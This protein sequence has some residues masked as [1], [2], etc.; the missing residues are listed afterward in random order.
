MRHI[1]GGIKWS[2]GANSTRAFNEG[3]VGA[4]AMPPAT[5]AAG[6]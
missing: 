5:S 2:L 1:I 3:C 4:T 6:Q